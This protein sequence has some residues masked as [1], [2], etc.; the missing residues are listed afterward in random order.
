M[1]APAPMSTSAAPRFF[2]VRV[3]S[4]PVEIPLTF[5]VYLNVGEKPVLFRKIGDRLTSERMKSLMK[6][7]ANNFLVPQDQ[8]DQYLAM[9]K[10]TISSP[11]TARE[12]KSRI[13]KESAFLHVQ[14]LF[15]KEDIK[16]VIASAKDL[17]EDMVSFVS[18][19]VE[20]AVSL[21]RLSIHDYYTYNH[22]VDVA[23]Y[24][25]ALA[26]KILGDNRDV[27]IMAGLGGLLHDVGKRRIDRAIINKTSPLTVAEWEEIKRHPSYGLEFIKDIGAIPQDS[28][29]AVFEHHENFDGSGYPRGLK[30]D[31]ISKLARIVMIADVFD[32]LTTDRSYHKAVT[33]KEALDTMFSMQPGKFDPNI[34]RSFNRNF[35]KKGNL[36]LPKDF[37]PCQ[38]REMV[39][40]K[41]E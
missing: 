5:D 6:H 38:A 35:E 29:R 23:V 30:E 17:V 11:D 32:A 39:K 1:T 41:I 27:L 7:G 20:A 33:P 19:D 34:F 15:T 2:V 36:E 8:R 21:M 14:D 16:P 24:S 28:K 10:Q 22:C 25:V 26:K 18:E 31:E 13:I 3:T 12:Q 9:L 37:D 40:Q 4:I